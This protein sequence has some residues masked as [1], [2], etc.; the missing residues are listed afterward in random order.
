MI[1]QHGPCWRSDA[2]RKEPAKQHSRCHLLIFCKC[3][4]RSQHVLQGQLFS[5]FLCQS[6]SL[7]SS[8]FSP[9]V[10][11]TRFDSYPPS[12]P[13]SLWELF[14]QQ[15]FAVPPSPLG[16]DE[17]PSCPDLDFMPLSFHADKQLGHQA[18]KVDML[19]TGLLITGRINETM[20]SALEKSLWALT[21]GCCPACS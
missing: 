4:A 14:G 18:Q 11:V 12:S 9:L 8:P 21:G 6:S 2:I 3:Q 17:K 13:L 10:P 16:E 5:L 7:L 20:G 15:T 19:W 1:T